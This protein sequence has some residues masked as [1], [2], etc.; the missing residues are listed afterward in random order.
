MSDMTNLLKSDLLPVRKIQLMRILIIIISI[1]V[2][3]CGPL[4]QYSFAQSILEEKRQTNLD[5]IDSRIEELKKD[6]EELKQYDSKKRNTVKGHQYIGITDEVKAKLIGA[7]DR[8]TVSLQ[9]LRKKVASEKDLANMRQLGKSINTHYGLNFLSILQ[10]K[11]VI[12]IDSMNVGLEE[13]KKALNDTADQYDK[14]K[15]CANYLLNKNASPSTTTNQNSPTRTPNKN[16]CDGLDSEKVAQLY[17]F[18]FDSSLKVSMFAYS[19]SSSIL[20]SIAGLAE[21]QVADYNKKIEKIESQIGKGGLASLADITDN[22]RLTNLVNT[23]TDSIDATRTAIDNIAKQLDSVVESIATSMNN[24]KNL[25][26]KLVENIKEDAG[27]VKYA[28]SSVTERTGK[29][30]NNSDRGAGEGGKFTAWLPP[31]SYSG[32]SYYCAIDI[33][34]VEK[35]TAVKDISKQIITLCNK[36]MPNVKRLTS[37]TYHYPP[38]QILMVGENYTDNIIKDKNWCTNNVKKTDVFL[39]KA[40]NGRI[41]VCSA[42]YL[43]KNPTDATLI[44]NAITRMTQRYSNN[45]PKWIVAAIPEYIQNK[46]GYTSKD[47][48]MICRKNQSY[49]SSSLC[50]ASF[51]AYLSKKSSENIV[52][53]IH[54]AASVERYSDNIILNA[55]KTKYK[56]IDEL[57]NA[58][59]A[60][61]SSCMLD[62]SS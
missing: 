28:V 17:D 36:E 21:S 47:E 8:Q 32:N 39:S 15:A 49:K 43:L 5:I 16:P 9:D 60:K 31:Y 13:S 30:I 45:E 11:T 40:E 42:V 4:T 22:T 34:R 52:R 20:R 25:A 7:L 59:C 24:I 23:L 56:S 50:A 6:A 51:L 33:S 19:T 27:Y 55:V 57:F 46:L 35:N 62:P 54:L 29:L 1:V 44:V 3:I 18:Q 53:R 41:Y 58:E 12:A 26:D 48:T 2:S 38:I 14:L 61:D 37:V 10:A